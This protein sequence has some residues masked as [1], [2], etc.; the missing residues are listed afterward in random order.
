[1]YGPMTIF[2]LATV[3]Q[4]APGG[5]QITSL[6]QVS[7]REAR[8]TLTLPSAD[9]DGTP[10]TGLTKLTVVTIAPF[11]VANPLEGPNPFAGLSAFSDALAVPGVTRVDLP[12]SSEDAGRQVDIVLPVLAAGRHQFF[13]AACTDDVP[14]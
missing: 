5:L 6:Q 2:D 1:M 4:T 12:L 14:A 3:D 7:N 9:A 11:D 13:A 10:L 8:A